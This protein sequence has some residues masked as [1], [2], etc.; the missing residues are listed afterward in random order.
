[1]MKLENLREETE[2]ALYGLTADDSLKYRILQKAAQTPIEETKRNFRPFPVLC[3][4]LAV[5]LLLTVA[6]NQVRPLSTIEAGDITVFAAGR[7]EEG[8]T[9]VFSNIEASD[10]ISMELTSVGKIDT[11]EDCSALLGVLR[12]DSFPAADEKWDNEE[13]LVI[14]T[15]DGQSIR[16]PVNEPYFLDNTC[17]ECEAVFDQFRE[18]TGK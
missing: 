6:L 13:Y 10:I 15:A 17:W 12:Q 3:S 9:S 8:S 4:V 5:L 1:M 14:C 11:P 16:Y 2:S 18:I 7:K